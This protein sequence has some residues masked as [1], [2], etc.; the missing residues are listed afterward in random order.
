[1]PHAT[2]QYNPVDDEADD[3]AI[4]RILNP[5]DPS[6]L[7]HLPFLTRDLV[8]GDKADDAIDYEDFGDD[9]LPDDDDA[10]GAQDL[11]VA[12]SIQPDAA[13]SLN[14]FLRDGDIPARTDDGGVKDGGMDDLFGETPSSPVYAIGDTGLHDADDIFGDD[15]ERV[16]VQPGPHPTQNPQGERDAGGQ[17][18]IQD[19]PQSKDH[20]IQM[21]LFSM[22]TNVAL[23]SGQESPPAPPENQEEL[24]ASLWPKFEREAIPKFIDLLPPKKARYVGKI[25]SKP[26]KP[27]NPTKISLE[28]SQDQ[29]KTFRIWP[30]S[31]NRSCED[32][33]QLG[34]VVVGQDAVDGNTDEEHKDLESD[35]ENEAVG[36]VPWEDLKIVCEDWDVHSLVESQESDE[37]ACR[38]SLLGRSGA[39]GGIDHEGD[40]EID[41]PTAKV[42]GYST[43]DRITLIPNHR[44]GN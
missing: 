22:S 39:F 17:F 43:L 44:D 16:H 40:H 8:P 20:Q 25:I 23:R 26:P 41:S 7:E 6:D 4:G 18:S 9:D 35:Y 15:S 5:G 10:V 36:G 31:N 19:T 1:M 27:V 11:S 38:S 3:I 28:L 32:T 37:P 12:Q 42:N 30:A 21:R 24:L 33:K 14:T 2:G 29:E 34:V 13:V